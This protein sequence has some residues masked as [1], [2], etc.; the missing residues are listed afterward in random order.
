MRRP[1]WATRS[2][3][4]DRYGPEQEGGIRLP[5]SNGHDRCV[6]CGLVGELVG[7]EVLRRHPEPAHV[8]IV[9]GGLFQD[10]KG[11]S[12]LNSFASE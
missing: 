6:P 11:C 1:S 12:S 8:Q 7:G 5:P 10:R 2:I 4:C 9:L 3:L